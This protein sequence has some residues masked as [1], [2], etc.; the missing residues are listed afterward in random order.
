[1]D[2]ALRPGVAA[3]ADAISALVTGW[4]HFFLDDPAL[5]EAAPFLA[6]LTPAAT[7]ERLAS[8]EFSYTVAVDGAGLCGVIALRDS[9]HL[10]HL[11]VREDAHGRGIARTLWEHAREKSGSSVFI[12]NSSPPA[13]PV[14]ER[15]GFVAKEAPKTVN[16]LTF[17]PM[18]YRGQPPAQSAA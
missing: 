1:M 9:F 16:G 6:S 8:G 10:F 3:D 5:P 4:A 7:R 12:V 17:V 14:Y 15:F 11:F 13:V 2:F 18:E